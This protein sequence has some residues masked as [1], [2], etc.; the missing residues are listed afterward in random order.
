MT[1]FATGPTRPIRR[2]LIANRGEIAVRVI[3][4]CRDEGIE[5]VA[6]Y[7]DADRDAIFV[8]MADQAQALGGDKPAETYLD[9]GKIIAIAR[10]AGADAIHPG[11][12]FLSERA[13]FAQAV[14][15]A[16][17]IWIGPDPKVIEALGDKI[18]ARRIAEAVGAP[19]VAGTPGPVES[20]AEAL[21]FA[22]QHGLP[23]AIKAA[24]GGGGRGMKVAWRLEEV[25][26]LF[27]SATREALT[28]FGRGECF[29][30]QFLDRPRHVEA[31]V[32]ADKHGT[33]K[34]IGTRDCSL[35]RRNQ[36][37]VE[38]APAPFLTDE[39]RAR[40]HDSARAICAHAGYSGAGTVEY[41]LSANGT[42]SFLEVNT[43]LQVEH[44]VTEETTG[45]DLVRGMIRV[46]QGARLADETVPEPR[47]HAIEFRINAED[48][49]RGFLPT[50]GPVEVFDAPSGPGIRMDSGV[51]QGSVVPGSFD[52]LMAKLIV[53]GATRQ[54]A[55]QRAERA[56]REFRIE[57]VASV[58]PF[59][60][61]VLAQPDFRAED[62]DFRVH[63]RWIETDFAEALAEAVAPHARVAPAAQAPLLRLAIEIDGKRHELGLPANLLSALPAGGASAVQP[64]PEADEAVLT[65]PVPGTLTLWQAEDEAEVEQGQVVA[66][67]EAMKME[68]RIEAH[69]AG[70]LTRIAAQG[71][72]LGFG[73]ALAR[74]D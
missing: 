66:V 48:P 38:E 32:L 62:G 14:Q 26:E 61:A 49:A 28:A 23:I 9:A 53:T 17:L 20:P 63:T 11:Y 39:Q 55:L 58:L 19:L 52:S 8:R 21:A 2:L 36:K 13:E 10:A 1:I 31:Q 40:I 5:S 46:A 27:E 22:R 42:I 3:R 68:T 29:I 67:I 25:E 12:G 45:I 41:L 18:E 69:R 33:V 50:P 15:D 72:V 24:F 60:R 47:G 70:K 44:P 30:E 35:Q 74:I 59:A 71:E 56:L 37:L 6:V 64:A 51:A 57:G 34:V 54:E 7:A 73:A 43:R 65:A 16:G 4:A